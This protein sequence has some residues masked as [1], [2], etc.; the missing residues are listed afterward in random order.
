MVEQERSTKKVAGRKPVL[1]DA[2]A[3]EEKTN[4]LKYM[5]DNF[6]T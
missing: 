2:D 5:R 3:L 4:D 6:C 1:P